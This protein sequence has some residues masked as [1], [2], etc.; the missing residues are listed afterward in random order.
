LG[1]IRGLSAI[2]DVAIEFVLPVL[3]QIFLDYS[4]DETSNKINNKQQTQSQLHLHSTT[5]TTTATRP[6][7]IEEIVDSKQKRKPKTDKNQS[8]DDANKTNTTN[9]KEQTISRKLKIRLEIGEALL[10]VTVLILHTINTP[11]IYSFF[12][13]C[14][15]ELPTYLWLL[16]R[17][18]YIT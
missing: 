13:L 2:G 9:D 11:H 15:T 8:N 1:A 4:T 16:L 3:R 5:I 17:K 14:R 18:I 12:H 7:L 10:Q 6:P